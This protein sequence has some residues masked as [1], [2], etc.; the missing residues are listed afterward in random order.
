MTE[1]TKLEAFAV[2]NLIQDLKRQKEQIEFTLNSQF[3][4]PEIHEALNVRLSL[5]RL[6]IHIAKEV[7]ARNSA[8][9]FTINFHNDKNI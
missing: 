1:L 2:F 6:Y 7:Y 4:V 5:M 9:C 3:V 8:E